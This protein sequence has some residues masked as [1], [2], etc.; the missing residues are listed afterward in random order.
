M[1]ILGPAFVSSFQPKA[2]TRVH[3]LEVRVAA[4]PRRANEIAV[5][6]INASMPVLRSRC[7][8]LFDVGSEIGVTGRFLR[9]NLYVTVYITLDRSTGLLSDLLHYSRLDAN[10]PDLTKRKK[11]YA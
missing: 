1:E 4:N 8:R 5:N 2:R 10:A 6:K 9:H 3:R 7:R 11:S